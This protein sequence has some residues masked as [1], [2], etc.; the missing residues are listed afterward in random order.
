[1]REETEAGLMRAGLMD[2]RRV[3]GMMK[4]RVM[5]GVRFICGRKVIIVA[6]SQV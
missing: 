2:S 5:V 6:G 1:M 3:G 4:R